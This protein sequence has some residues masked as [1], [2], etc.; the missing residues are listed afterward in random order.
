MIG[1]SSIKYSYFTLFVIVASLVL[2][3][4]TIFTPLLNSGDD[5]FFMYTLAGGFGEEPTNL[6]H[7]NQGWHP[8]LGGL[9]STLFTNWPGVNW[10]SITLLV[11]HCCGLTALLYAMLKTLKPGIGI[12]FFLAI[13]LFIESRFLLSLNFTGTAFVT[14]TGAM[15]LMIYQVN[16]QKVFCV[17][18][19]SAFLLLLLS[20]M[21]RLH[22]VILVMLLFIPFIISSLSKKAKLSIFKAYLLSGIVLL[23]L[24]K[25]QENFYIDNIPGWKKQESFRQALFYAYNRPKNPDVFKIAF[26]DS[27]EQELFFS[28]FLY[29]SAQFT[30]VRITEISSKIT[31]KRGLNNKEDILGLYWFFMELRIYFLLIITF[32]ITFFFSKQIGQIHRWLIPMITVLFVYAY[33]FVFLKITTTIHLGLLFVLLVQI[34]V[35]FQ[36]VAPV[37]PFKW[38]RLFMGSVFILLVAW[39]LARLNKENDIN[40]ERR[41]NFNCVLAELNQNKDKLFIATDDSFPLG[42]FYLWDTPLQFPVSNLV[43]KDRMLTHTYLKTLKRYG[44]NDLH[45]ALR[46]N[47]NIRLVGKKLLSLEKIL[48]G[49][50]ISQQMPDFKCMEVRKLERIQ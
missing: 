11:F 50:R 44:V 10:Y 19:V 42:H 48:D 29:D 15:S 47:T 16:K 18:N 26:K 23:L 6:L 1:G 30:P 14:S 36:G 2:V 3:F 24:N 12:L 38:I 7:Y 25:A 35:G 34:S 45:N 27:T 8:W 13:F 49:V 28:S 40:K 20:G 37:F 41:R 22:V 39:M 33:L 5:A 9:L 21:L 32:V 46:E 43:Y 31:R 17:L 4:T